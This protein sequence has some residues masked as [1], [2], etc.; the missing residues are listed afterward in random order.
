MFL[1]QILTYIEH[2]VILKTVDEHDINFCLID[3]DGLKIR[4][5]GGSEILRKQFFLNVSI[6]G[7]LPGI[8]SSILIL[9]NSFSEGNCDLPTEKDNFC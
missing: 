7:Y 3:S 1:L 9:L 8:H 5:P 2:I 4:A 6:P